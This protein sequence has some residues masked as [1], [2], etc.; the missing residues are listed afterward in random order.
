MSE[1]RDWILVWNGLL[2]EPPRISAD[3]ELPEEA[4]PMAPAAAE[5]TPSRE[6]QAPASS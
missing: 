2:D 3:S 6:R 5:R 4:E 1:R